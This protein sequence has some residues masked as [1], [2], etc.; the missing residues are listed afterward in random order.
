MM[1]S[2]KSR[3]ESKAKLEHKLYLAKETP[4][5]IFDLSECDI[6]DVPQGIYSLCR[7]FLKERLL[8]D[9]NSLSSLSGGGN[10]AELKFLKILNISHN[11]FVNLPDSIGSLI[12]LQEFYV[13]YNSLKVLPNSIC[14][15]KN[16]QILDISH[17]K[18][19]QLP[20]DI[21]NLQSLK[22]LDLLGNNLKRLPTSICQAQR[23]VN[24]SIDPEH[25]EYPPEE[26]VK[27][28]REAILRYICDDIGV[29][30]KK[31]E[32]LSDVLC[33]LEKSVSDFEDDDKLWQQNKVRQFL[34]I[35]KLNELLQRQE[36]EL[37][38]AQKLNREKLLLDIAKEQD[39][40][41]SRL[42]KIQQVKE[43]E[44]F[45]LIEQ[46]HEAEQNAYAAIEQ[47]L[48][49]N[50]E[51]LATLLDYEKQEEERL[52]DAANAHNENLKKHEILEAMRN[53][54]EQEGRQFENIYQQRV[55]MSKSILQ[56]ETEWT[57][58]I[59]ELMN[60]H[61]SSKRDIATKI[62]SDMEL[63]K[64]ALSTLLE[65]NDCRSWGLLQQ[66]SLVES[67]LAALT[68][69]ELDRRKLNLDEQVKDFAEKRIELSI[70][71]MDLLEQQ[72][73]RRSE[74]LATLK[75]L[76]DNWDRK[77][78]DYWLKQYQA[79]LNRI[80]EGL[81]ECQKN[82]DPL[83]AEALLM[84]GVI[85]CLPHLAKIMQSDY[86]LEFVD[87]KALSE[88]GISSRQDRLNILDA[89]TF[90]NKQKH[91]YEKKKMSE[92]R[93]VPEVTEQGPSAPPLD[94]LDFVGGS[95]TECVV[96][97]DKECQV[98]F[99]PCGHIVCC[100]ACSGNLSQCPFCRV[101]IERKIRILL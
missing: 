25:F 80:P 51:P 5:P 37:A 19:K 49:I 98:I 69:I 16:L 82:I 89:F 99:V 57:N 96:C 54:L 38:S 30:Y 101:N 72:D 46:L 48:A 41:D 86:K 10:L 7:V 83:L 2:R 62:M 31:V 71:L 77:S 79:L 91:Q 93:E 4:E 21:G 47:L 15:L 11:N 73:L 95:I 76:E 58:K 22:K 56:R 70:L 97:M 94:H 59:S 3:R 13:S 64:A 50:R 26:V 23:L 14:E 67:Q 39:E 29:E 61:D 92:T 36:L 74:L 6:K 66:V 75:T 84:N 43:Q 60:V 52:I 87:E 34:E 65:R 27:R 100:L 20:E 9:S 78:Q 85:H 44:K 40:F 45:R 53:I 81:V 35:E 1:F 33:N 88:A 17:N 32:D 55:E 90:Y 24:L 68:Q 8:L 63:Q 42:S 12:S 18:L 28:G